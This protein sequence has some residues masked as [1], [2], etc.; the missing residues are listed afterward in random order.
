MTDDTAVSRAVYVLPSTSSVT[1][2]VDLYELV[3]LVS[4]IHFSR[5]WVRFFSAQLQ[6]KSISTFFLQHPQP[7]TNI[8]GDWSVFILS[9]KT[10]ERANQGHNG[11]L[12]C[13]LL[14]TS[15]SNQEMYVSITLCCF[16]FPPSN[17]VKAHLSGRDAFQSTVQVSFTVLALSALLVKDAV[18]TLWHDRP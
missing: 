1:K 10:M 14:N 5:F 7:V 11:N 12:A 3:Q 13:F 4:Y 9:C 18:L 2:C 16:L 17:P 15:C 6:W 8:L